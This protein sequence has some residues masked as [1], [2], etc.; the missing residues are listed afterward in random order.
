[1]ENKVVLFYETQCTRLSCLVGDV[2][3]IGY[4]SRLFSLVLSVLQTEQF[5]PVLS[6]C[7]RVCKQV[8]VANWKLGRDKTKLFTLHFET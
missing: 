2:N 1:M 7:E 6:A 3:R 4:I 8:L 5:C